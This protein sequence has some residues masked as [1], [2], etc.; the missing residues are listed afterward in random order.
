M[1]DSGQPGA[2]CLKGLLVILF[3]LFKERPSNFA[4]ILKLARM[5]IPGLSFVRVATVIAFPNTVCKAEFHS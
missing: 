3:V 2:G 4:M 5:Y 1:G